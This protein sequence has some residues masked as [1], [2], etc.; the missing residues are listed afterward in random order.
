MAHR[1][2][3]IDEVIA[4][5]LAAPTPRDAV[6]CQ[7]EDYKQLTPH[8]IR[9]NRLVINY[10]KHHAERCGV[11]WQAL[12]ATTLNALVV[13]TMD[14]VRSTFE[15]TYDRFTRVFSSHRIPPIFQPQ[16][17][18]AFADTGFGLASVS[19]KDLFLKHLSPD[20]VRSCATIF[21]INPEWLIGEDD[22]PTYFPPI[23]S[24][25]DVD[26]CL[27][28]AE[29][30]RNA[31]SRA[32]DLS[33]EGLE[34]R[35]YREPDVE[36]ATHPS[37]VLVSANLCMGSGLRFCAFVP[38]GKIIAIG[39]END[40]IVTA[41]TSSPSCLRTISHL[42]PSTI[43][44]MATGGLPVELIGAT[45]STALTSALPETA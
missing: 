39:A 9:P 28:R 2:L 35:V 38:V 7:G 29:T 21:G 42:P 5:M 30:Y 11:S 13:R 34:M 41:L 12:V 19:N 8:T 18:N 27:W 23:R 40:R 14:P 37:I 20:V 6:Y 31:V 45:G 1:R 10:F 43:R 36:T 24:L 44:R 22:F 26:E 15:V 32:K 17:A 25:D 16:I 4:D 3:S 33:V